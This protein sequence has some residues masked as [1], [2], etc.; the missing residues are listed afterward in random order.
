MWTPPELASEAAPW[1]SGVWRVVE[2]QSQFC[3]MKIVDTSDEQDL[4]ESELDGS[5]RTVPASCRHLNYLL[6]TPFRYAPYPHGSR[7]RR[8]RQREGCF[9]ASDGVAT[10]VVEAAFYQLLFFLDAPGMKRPANPQPRTA[11]HVP[12]AT[13]K[14]LDLTQPP[15]NADGA[16]W[17]HPTD[18]RA[19]QELAD[20]ARVAGVEALRYRSVRDPAQGMN[21]A[22]LSPAAFRGTAPDRSQTWRLFL[23]EDR[24]QARC[25]MPRTRLEIPYTAWAADPRVHPPRT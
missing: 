20:N 10:A 2:S 25:E 15:L 6:S 17:E 19:C 3:T 24:V 11:I 12:V 1:E 21:V 22:L 18:Y 9:Y 14:A 8:R 7:F 4:L 5:K 13:A 16:R 23:R